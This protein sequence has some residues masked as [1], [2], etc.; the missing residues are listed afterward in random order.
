MTKEAFERPEWWTL[1]FDDGFAMGVTIADLD[2][3]AFQRLADAPAPTDPLFVEI[4]ASERERWDFRGGEMSDARF[5][6]AEWLDQIRDETNGCGSGP[7]EA[8]QC[9]KAI[10][11]LG[12][13][14]LRSMDRRAS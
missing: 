11:V 9:L 2:A 5:S 6:M 12:L 1:R 4:A 3:P 13:A 8:E 10:V 7:L 14:A